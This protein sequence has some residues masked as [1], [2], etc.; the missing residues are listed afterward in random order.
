MEQSQYLI[1]KTVGKGDITE[2]SKTSNKVTEFYQNNDYKKIV[3][4]TGRKFIEFLE[5]GDKHHS[6]KLPYSAYSCIRTG[7]EGRRRCIRI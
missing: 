4:Q 6:S 1:C 5:N 7:Q 3:S 2:I